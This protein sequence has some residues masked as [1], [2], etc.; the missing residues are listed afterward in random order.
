MSTL[1]LVRDRGIR[2][3]DWMLM[4][5]ERFSRG[6]P[7]PVYVKPCGGL[8]IARKIAQPRAPS[9]QHRRSTGALACATVGH[10]VVRP[11]AAGASPC[12][13]GTL[14]PVRFFALPLCPHSQEW[15]CYTERRVA[16]PEPS[17]GAAAPPRREQAPALQS[18][19][20]GFSP[21]AWRHKAASTANAAFSRRPRY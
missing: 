1:L 12:S 10:G 8:D 19:R 11:T 17:R 5:G 20:G 15:L 9:K 4:A 18:C 7:R 2:L 6:D 13:T 3:G 14:L 21:P 16:C